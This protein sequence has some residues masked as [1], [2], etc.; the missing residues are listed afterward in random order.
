MNHL[1]SDVIRLRP[2]AA[3][4]GLAFGLALAPAAQAL[5]ID[6]WNT[7]SSSSVLDLNADSTA[8]V[9]A[10]TSVGGTSLTRGAMMADLA[11]GDAVRTQDCANCKQGHFVNDAN[12]Q[13]SGY[14]QWTASPFDMGPGGSVAIDYGTDVSGGDML[15]AFLSGGILRGYAQPDSK[16]V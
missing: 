6:D 13:G 10:R 8:V 3:A 1:N 9:A 14:W 7:T 2:A 16:R 15:V 12:S 5:V 4:V 11:S